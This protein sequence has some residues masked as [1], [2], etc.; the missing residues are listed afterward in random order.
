M[1]SCFL[2]DCE[3]CGF[4]GAT[5]VKEC[6]D[7]MNDE[8][9]AIIRNQTWDLMSKPKEVKPITCK[10]VYKVKCKADGNVDRYKAS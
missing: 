10:W 2:D 4:D 8:T 6:D 7:D 3:L 9:N 1:H 5:S